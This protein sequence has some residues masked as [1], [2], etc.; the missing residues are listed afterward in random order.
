VAGAFDHGALDALG[1]FPMDAGKF[2]ADFDP[3]PNP[4][5]FE[6]SPGGRELAKPPRIQPFLPTTPTLNPGK[7]IFVVSRRYFEG[8]PR[9]HFVGEVNDCSDNTVRATDFV[10]VMNAPNAFERKPEIRTRMFPLSDAR[11]L[12][13]VIP[14][15]AI[16]SQIHS[17][18]MGNRLHLSDD[19]EFLCDVDEFRQV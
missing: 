13:H 14:A 18:N 1:D 2:V 5:T 15:I 7:K 12:I 16:L 17:M 19:D 8:D 11:V 10:F 6:A 9:R 4:S 3:A